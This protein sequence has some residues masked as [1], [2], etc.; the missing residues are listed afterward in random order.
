MVRIR[1]AFVVCI[2]HTTLL[3]LCKSHVCFYL[4]SDTSSWTEYQI[5]TTVATATCL[6]T[7]IVLV[8]AR[9]SSGYA[10]FIVVSVFS[11][12]SGMYICLA[13]YAKFPFSYDSVQGRELNLCCL[14]ALS[15]RKHAYIILTPLNPTFI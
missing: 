14:I 10:K 9:Q 13:N 7:F 6:L 5:L 11:P 3:L 1:S 15:S 8:C 4:L 2:C 12:V